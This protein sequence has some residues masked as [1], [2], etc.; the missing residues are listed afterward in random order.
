MGDKIE[1]PHWCQDTDLEERLFAHTG[2]EW[3]IHVGPPTNVG[4]IILRLTR[5]DVNGQPGQDRIS[6][7]CKAMEDLPLDK[8][9]ELAEPEQ[10][11]E[12]G[13]A[14]AHLAEHAETFTGPD[15]PPAAT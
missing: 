7:R 10:L 11:T 5:T 2:P 1:H 9:R 13:N 14:L 4:S 3:A 8:A 6:I 12:L 15:P